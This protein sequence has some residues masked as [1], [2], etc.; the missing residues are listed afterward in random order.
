MIRLLAAAAAA[1]I[2]APATASARDCSYPGVTFPATKAQKFDGWRAVFKA[3]RPGDAV[4]ADDAA[5]GEELC[6]EKGCQ[7]KPELVVDANGMGHLVVRAPG[8]GL[9]LVTDLD[10]SDQGQCSRQLFTLTRQG[11]DYVLVTGYTE[12]GERV[13]CEEDDEDCPGAA[14]CSAGDEYHHWLFDLK[15]GE[16]MAMATCGE[17]QSSDRPTAVLAAP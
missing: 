17:L 16:L 7:A 1:L 9:W 5:I 2:L 11:D 4:P 3:L 15:A 6:W 13:Y 8:G 14:C 12:W 10:F